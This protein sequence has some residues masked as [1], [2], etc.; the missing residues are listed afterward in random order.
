MPSTPTLLALA[1]VVSLLTAPDSAAATLCRE[2]YTADFGGDVGARHG[3]GYVITQKCPEGG[4]VARQPAPISM[5]FGPAPPAEI[6]VSP[7]ADVPMET[8]PAPSATGP[9]AGHHTSPQGPMV[10]IAGE[11][12]PPGALAPGPT[13]TVM[14]D[15]DYAGLDA[16][17][18]R[19]LEQIPAGAVKVT[20]Y[21]CRTGRKDYNLD[22]SRRRAQAVAAA[23]RARGVQVIA[24][25]GRGECCPAAATDPAQDRRVVIE[26]VRE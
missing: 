24:L 11:I 6:P 20:G 25:E 8:P 15:L 18:R 3:Q 9:D 19:L 16:G 10:G 12:D 22:L 21:A 14:F 7:T 17:A 2:N 13:W 4:L 23:L 5:R 26:E 1:T